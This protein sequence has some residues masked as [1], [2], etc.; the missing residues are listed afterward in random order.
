MSKLRAP[1][2]QLLDDRLP[3]A[4][5]QRIWREVQRK[6][7][8]RS[9]RAW[10]MPLMAATSLL[11][12][13]LAGWLGLR[14]VRD[15]GA[16]AIHGAPALG[17]SHV[18]GADVATVWPLDDGSR[19]QLAGASRLQVL[20][21]TGHTFV[22]RLESG[23]GEF[24]V[25]PGG[26]RRWRIDCGA[27]SV[28]VIGTGFVID[29]SARSVSV[30]VRHGVV[31][32]RSAQIAGGVQ[33]LSAG[34]RL[35]VPA[36]LQL[37]AAGST[38]EQATESVAAGSS[39]PLLEG[40]AE[41]AP[42]SAAE[43]AKSPPSGPHRDRASEPVESAAK[44]PHTSRSAGDAGSSQHSAD[45]VHGSSAKASTLPPSAAVVSLPPTAAEAPA[46]SGGADLA[47]LLRRADRA[48][49]NGQSS[50][51]E[52]LFERIRAGSPGSSHAAVASLTL[53]RMRIAAAP[54]RAAQDLSAALAAKLPE[55]LREDAMA[56]LVEA[57]ARAG[58]LDLARTAAQ[59][60][61]RAFPHGRRAAEI[62][63]WTQLP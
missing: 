27:L 1:I 40:Q 48:R 34:E 15:S 3:E 55:A 9:P 37:S 14:S 29:R 12:L 63:R 8:R 4:Q 52:A 10:L 41:H 17:S 25:K 49:R 7:H 54:E 58:Q 24:E 51:A 50:E 61:R 16:L 35:D 39:P 5:V 60:Y 13:G 32:V 38:A 43:Q 21:N 44:A 47:G 2:R 28:E 53:A 46:R 31:R 22:A 11:L 26:P 6:E 23:R 30:A 62:E 57:H 45:H 56:R 18:L 20:E 19:I 36:E 59:A 42:E 33:R